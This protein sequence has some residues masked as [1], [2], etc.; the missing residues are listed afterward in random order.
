MGAIFA[1]LDSR[2]QIPLNFVGD[3]LRGKHKPC[4]ATSGAGLH[5]AQIKRL[6]N[7]FTSQFHQA[8]TREARQM[9]FCPISRKRVLKATKQLLPMLREFHINEIDHDNA[10][11]IPQ[12][13]LMAI[14]A[15]ASQLM[16][17][18]VS[19]KE[20]FPT[21]FPVFTSIAVSASAWSIT[22]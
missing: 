2:T 18:T 1:N 10:A 15:A 20:C 17:N 19:S 11:H 14:S 16:A 4:A 9:D 5:V 8:K 3:G 21:N 7:A 22:K 13:Q 6:L 12:T